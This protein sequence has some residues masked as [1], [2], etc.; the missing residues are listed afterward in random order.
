MLRAASVIPETTKDLSGNAD[1]NGLAV[2]E[3]DIATGEISRSFVGAKQC[4]DALPRH[5]EL[6]H[7]N[8]RRERAPQLGH[9]LWKHAL[10][11]IEKVVVAVVNGHGS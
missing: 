3:E 8:G 7:R 4:L 9:K 2:F 5:E 1:I 11:E 6:R 10:R